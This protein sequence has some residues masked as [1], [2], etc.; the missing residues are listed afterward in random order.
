MKSI[1]IIAALI[2]SSNLFSQDPPEKYQ[3]LWLQ[4][5]EGDPQV[6]I[7]KLRKLV[8]KEKND[9][10]PYWMLGIALNHGSPSEEERECFLKSL[11][12]DSTFGPAHYGYAI[13]LDAEE[14]VNIATIEY[15]F[16]KAIEYTA[17]QDNF[18]YEPRARFYYDQ[19][20]YDEAI[21]DAKKHKELNPDNAYF[22]NQVIV[23]SLYAQGKKDELKKFLRTYSPLNEAG[24]EDPEYYYFLATVYD[25]FNDSKTACIYYKQAVA[26]E[27]FYIEIF[28][29]EEG[30]KVPDWYE[31]TKKK[32]E[33]CH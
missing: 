28:G 33:N 27:Q 30:F 22:A 7:K 1:L 25:E 31:A 10:W 13:S 14:P 6:A 32:A 23:Q 9:P 20:R 4:V 16:N 8:K 29:E 24:P 21:A 26:D 18:Y 2:I 3:E 19:K 17:P 5:H 15:H 11:Q 12:I